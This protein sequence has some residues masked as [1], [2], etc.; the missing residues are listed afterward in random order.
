[1][2]IHEDLENGLGKKDQRRITNIADKQFAT[3]PDFLS[4]A[5][6]YFAREAE[7]A[8]QHPVM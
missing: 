3:L 7:T 1:V 5:E 2:I 4:V 6:G 8:R